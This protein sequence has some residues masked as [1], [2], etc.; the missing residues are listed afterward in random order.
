MAPLTAEEWWV[1]REH[2]RV[3]E[4]CIQEC[5]RFAAKRRMLDALEARNTLVRDETTGRMTS[6]RKAA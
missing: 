2:E 6:E 1:L 3:S 4:L 5:E